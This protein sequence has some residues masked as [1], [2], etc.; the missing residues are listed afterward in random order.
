MDGHLVQGLNQQ[1]GTVG[2]DSPPLA[3]ASSILLVPSGSVTVKK[4][5]VAAGLPEGDSRRMLQWRPKTIQ[6]SYSNGQCQQIVL[7]DV[8]GLQE[9]DLDAVDT[10]QVMLSIID[11]YPPATDQPDDEISVT[12]LRLFER[13]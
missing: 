8:P 1:P 9:K 5:S 13:G 10:S 3:G 6:L 12:E 2:C 4:I 7:E 11:A